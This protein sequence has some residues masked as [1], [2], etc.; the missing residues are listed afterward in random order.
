MQQCFYPMN[1]TE[2]IAL[3]DCNNFFAS[4]ERL[5]NPSLNG[6]PVAVLSNNDGCI[7]SRSNEVKKMGVPMGAPLFEYRDL[8]EKNNT[9]IISSNHALY[10]EISYQVMEVLREDIGEEAMEIYSIDEAFLNVGVPDKLEM[11]GNHIKQKVFEKSGI[12]VSVGIAETKT[13]S[14]IAN[15]IAKKSEKANGMLNLYGSPYVDFALKKTEVRDIW[16]IGHKNAKRLN[17]LNIFTALELKNADP[18]KIRKS[19]NVFGARTVLELRGIKCLPIE[20]TYSDKKSIAHT[21]TFG[22]T[23]SEYGEVKN[24]LIYFAMRAAEK[25]RRDGL[26]AKSITCFVKTD[27]FNRNQTYYSQSFTLDLIYATNVNMEICKLIP[28]CLDKIY[29][30]NLPYKRA[31][32]IFGGLISVEKNPLRL[33]GQEK[34]ERWQ[35][36]DKLS[37]ELN[38][39]FGRDFMRL[40]NIKQT[41]IW[42]SHSTH[43]E[44]DENHEIARTQLGLGVNLAVFRKFI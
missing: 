16:G 8:L 15:Q 18:A 9:A 4:C 3:I 36:L 23:I 14:K 13:L 31:G 43:H 32:V 19:L 5:V 25:M 1:S 2:A 38:F 21:R 20:T 27:R 34:F 41:G 37:D 10:C 33:F 11:F 17:D 24:A 35:R 30:P 39:R 22:A 40:A 29:R 28:A 6:R 7:I 12:P 44:N 42:H 26:V